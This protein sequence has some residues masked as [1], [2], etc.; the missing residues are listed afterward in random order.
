MAAKPDGQTIGVASTNTLTLD[1]YANEG[2]EFTWESFDYPGTT[3]AVTFGL[4]ALADRPYSTLEEF[5]EYARENGR[6]TI[7]TSSMVLEIVVEKIA[8]HYEV[9]ARQAR[10]VKHA[11]E[12]R[13]NVNKYATA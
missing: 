3:M 6:A 8:D 11:L 1:P 7:S 9:S 4:V 10:K 5:V 12:N 13:L 2:I